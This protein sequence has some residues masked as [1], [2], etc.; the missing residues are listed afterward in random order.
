MSG[1]EGLLSDWWCRKHRAP[2]ERRRRDLSTQHGGNPGLEQLQRG[3][4]LSV[5][6]PSSISEQ[7]NHG[8]PERVGAT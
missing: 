6:R 2:G 3:A 7:M 8:V 5:G 1:T 4:V